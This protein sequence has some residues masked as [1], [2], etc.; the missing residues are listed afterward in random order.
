MKV[1][2]RN[3]C[4]VTALDFQNDFFAIFMIF[5][6]SLIITWYKNFYNSND[7]ALEY[8]KLK[9]LNTVY[10]KTTK[11]TFYVDFL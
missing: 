2:V 10:T 5:S 8:P 6:I 11:L 7:A 3:I 9:F 4:S 1:V